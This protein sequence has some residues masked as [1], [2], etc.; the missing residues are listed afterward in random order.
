[1]TLLLAIAQFSYRK[2]KTDKTLLYLLS[3]ILVLILLFCFPTLLPGQYPSTPSLMASTGLDFLA[4]Y[5]GS[6]LLATDAADGSFY[7]FL[8]KPLSRD[9][10]LFGKYLG[11]VAM[12][13]T[14]FFLPLSELM[15][16]DYLYR[17]GD[18]IFSFIT[19]MGLNFSISLA[20]LSLALFLSVEKYTL[21]TLI[22]LTVLLFLSFLPRFLPPGFWSLWLMY[23][24]GAWRFSAS[25]GSPSKE[26]IF[27]V[28]L[29]YIYALLFLVFAFMKFRRR[30]LA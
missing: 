30:E 10:Y 18:G 7:Y 23:Y 17:K 3:G 6:H 9:E 29:G 19:L 20:F 15:A 1:M 22:F 21:Q 4:I 26:V 12:L 13:L 2:L 28:I 24:P 5:I 16:V 14:L 11:G 8:S 27:P 25:V